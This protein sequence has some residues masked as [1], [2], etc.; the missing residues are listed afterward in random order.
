[1]SQIRTL[2]KTSTIAIAAALMLTACG[3]ANDSKA[4]DGVFAEPNDRAVP[5]D[6][7]SMKSSFA[8][9]VPFAQR[10]VMVNASA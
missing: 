5:T 3:N 8:P 10:S 6:A 7:M 2:M 1:M 4:Q 9:V